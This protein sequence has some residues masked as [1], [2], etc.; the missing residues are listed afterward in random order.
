MTNFVRIYRDEVE[1]AATADGA[2]GDG[3]RAVL[4]HFDTLIAEYDSDPANAAH[5]V[6]DEWGIG[7]VPLADNED[8]PF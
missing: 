7:Y 4:D 8:V 6:L 3:L 1:I 2:D 5:L